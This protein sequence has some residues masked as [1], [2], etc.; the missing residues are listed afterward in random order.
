[1]KHHREPV[2]S[3]SGLGSPTK[4]LNLPLAEPA[5][6]PVP[7][8]GPSLLLHPAFPVRCFHPQETGTLCA[9]NTSVEQKKSEEEK[10][11]PSGLQ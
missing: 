3:E 6:Q 8:S 4:N 2:W 1:M 10:G 9:T 7:F 11:R 5:E